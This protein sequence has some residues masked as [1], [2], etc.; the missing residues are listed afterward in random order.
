LAVLTATDLH[1]VFLRERVPLNIKFPLAIR[2][3]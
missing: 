3:R 2:V 1:N